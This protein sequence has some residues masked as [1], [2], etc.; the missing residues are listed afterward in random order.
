MQPSGGREAAPVAQDDDESDLAEIDSAISRIMGQLE[1]ENLPADDRAIL[2][3][4]LA[5]LTE[6]RLE[7]SNGGGSSRG[8]FAT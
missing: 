4:E 1:R 5:I 7:L 3:K 6:M 2:Q 8:M